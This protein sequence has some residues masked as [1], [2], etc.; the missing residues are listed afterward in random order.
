M[1]KKNKLVLSAV[2]GVLVTAASHAGEVGDLDLNADIAENAAR[3]E[4]H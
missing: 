1:T 2:A 3:Y 4:H